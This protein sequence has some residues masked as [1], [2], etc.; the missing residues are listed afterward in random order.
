LKN[1]FKVQEEKKVEVEALVRAQDIKFQ[2]KNKVIKIQD[3]HHL[4]KILNKVEAMRFLQDLIKNQRNKRMII[5][6]IWI[7]ILMTNME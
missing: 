4:T 6:H 3:L 7:M 5:S 1:K 2:I